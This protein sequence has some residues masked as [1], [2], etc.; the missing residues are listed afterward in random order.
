MSEELMAVINVMAYGYEVSVSVNGI[1][2]GIHGG[3]SE[4]KRL[5]GENDPNS[6]RL[7]PDMKN[8]A[9]LKSG[10]NELEIVHRVLKAEESTGLTIEIKS[11]EQFTNDEY[12]FFLQEDPDDADNAPKNVTGKFSL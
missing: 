5:M 11:Q 10:E 2:I 6:S 1:D 7:P 3:K 9:C 4:S 12:V 8:L